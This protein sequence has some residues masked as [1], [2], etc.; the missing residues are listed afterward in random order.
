V[1]VSIFQAPTHGI[2]LG[3]RATSA[4]AVPNGACPELLDPE[5]HGGWPGKAVQLPRFISGGYSMVF[6]SCFVTGLINKELSTF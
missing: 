6:P 4:G 5:L 3:L 1:I 2:E